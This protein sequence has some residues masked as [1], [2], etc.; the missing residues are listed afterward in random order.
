MLHDQK[1]IL[2]VGVW[3]VGGGAGFFSP[4]LKGVGVGG[5]RTGGGGRELKS[6]D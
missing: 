1:D 3:G 2:F 4:A 5:A 6:S